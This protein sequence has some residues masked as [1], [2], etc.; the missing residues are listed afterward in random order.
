MLYHSSS[1]MVHSAG[2]GISC[3]SN[4]GNTLRR[5]LATRRRRKHKAREIG[6]LSF[7][8]A[9]RYN[10]L[11]IWMLMFRYNVGVGLLNKC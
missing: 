11:K 10:L 1:T 8:L 2:M 3:S 5:L 9:V 4:T 6:G 7:F